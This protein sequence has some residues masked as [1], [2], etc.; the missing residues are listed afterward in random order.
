M[1]RVEELRFNDH[2]I[3]LAQLEKRWWVFCDDAAPHIDPHIGP[4]KLFVDAPERECRIMRTGSD[5]FAQLVSAQHL[6]Q[7]LHKHYS[8]NH[9]RMRAWLRTW[10]VICEARCASHG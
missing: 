5:S 3:R 8:V 4:E 10:K 1:A 7:W 9:N 2:T 6:L